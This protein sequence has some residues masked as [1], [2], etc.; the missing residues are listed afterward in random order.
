VTTPHAAVTAQIKN[1]LGHLM[2]NAFPNGADRLTVLVMHGGGRR[3]R[4]VLAAN[5]WPL[6]LDVRE[7]PTSEGSIE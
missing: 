1:I 5:C 6:A 3:A 7:V 4:E 2:V